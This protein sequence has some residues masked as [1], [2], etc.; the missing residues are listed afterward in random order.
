[1]YVANIFFSRTNILYCIVMIGVRLESEDEGRF[2]CAQESLSTVPSHEV[3]PTCSLLEESNLN[4]D[5]D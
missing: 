4:E 2:R 3:R 5:A 1:M